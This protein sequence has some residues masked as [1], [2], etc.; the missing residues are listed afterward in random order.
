MKNP[1]QL[2]YFTNRIESIIVGQGTLLSQAHLP[3]TL[4]LLQPI[5]LQNTEY[6]ARGRHQTIQSLPGAATKHLQFSARL[7]KNAH[8]HK[9][10]ALS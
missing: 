4:I 1:S 6:R 5:H 2:I 8:F 10:T 7:S 9:P 3:P